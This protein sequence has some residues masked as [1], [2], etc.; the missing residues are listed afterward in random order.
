MR[1]AFLFC[2]RIKGY[3][4]CYESFIKHVVRPL[5]TEYD[6]FLAHNSDNDSSDIDNFV[7]LYNVKKYTNEA[8]D[9]SVAIRVPK[10]P[11]DGHMLNGYSMFFFW[12]RAYELMDAYC[13]DNEVRYDIVMYLRA[14][15]VFTSNIHIPNI[16]P[17]YVYVPDGNDYLGGLNDQLAFGTSNIMKEYMDVYS[18]IDLIYSKTQIM[19]HPETYNRLNAITIKDI[20]V[21]RFPLEYTLHASRY[22]IS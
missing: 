15:T 9:L 1:I 5:N 6:S 12:K 20:Q 8:A 7:K 11:N 22:K 2:G 3:E 17:S 13:R 19:F 18:N 14:D 21:V 4:E 10:Q 16:E